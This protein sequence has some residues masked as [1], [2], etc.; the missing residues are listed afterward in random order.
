M[1][2]SGFNKYVQVH[3]GSMSG[4]LKSTNELKMYDHCC[5]IHGAARERR[6]LKHARI[7]ALRRQ[8]KREIEN[9]IEY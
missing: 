9:S 6:G 1:S 4:H 7:T 5:G 3:P 2:A 8:A